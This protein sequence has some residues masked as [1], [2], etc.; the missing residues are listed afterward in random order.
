MLEK[1]GQL[2]ITGYDEREPFQDF[3]KFLIEE[4][5]GGVILFEENSHPHT[6]AE[7][8]IR[9][10]NAASRETPFIAVDQEGGRVCRFRGAPAE[11][12]AASVFGKE[13]N[14]EMFYEH[15][16][17]SI[18]YIHSLGINL[19]LGPVADLELNNKNQCLKDRT[20]GKKPSRI[21]PFIETA[22]KTAARSGV[23]TCL[24]HFPGLGAASE[25]PHNQTA[26]ADYDLQT[27]L[28]RESLP[29]KAGI[30]AGA[31]MVMTSHI[32]LPNIAKHLAT[33]SPIIV[34]RLLRERLNFDG[35]AITDDL[36]MNGAGGAAEAP[37][38][39]VRA[40]MAG[41]DILLLGRD[42]STTKKTVAHFKDQFRKG[43]ISEERIKTSLDRI[44]GVKSKLVETVL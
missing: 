22:V 26:V 18:Y 37:R 6:R 40:F 28:N 2:F 30:D 34:E 19:L 10:I 23:L 5:I 4:N 15:F 31:D 27:F 1:I 21:I 38:M 9:Q 42:F 33:E 41:H 16:S 8:F 7:S 11:Y 32:L 17:R 43:G 35:V 36:L 14:L 3:L 20:F 25:D 24:K 13:N 44:Y 29:F 12:P 39:A